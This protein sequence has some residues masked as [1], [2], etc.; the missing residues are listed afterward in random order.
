MSAYREKYHRTQSIKNAIAEIKKKAL[1]D[2]SSAIIKYNFE[3]LTVK[4]PSGYTC[5][6]LP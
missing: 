1:S 6:L 3:F 4:P 5:F 2:L